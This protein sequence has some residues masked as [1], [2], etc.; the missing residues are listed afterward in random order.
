MSAPRKTIKGRDFIFGTLPASTALKVELAIAPVLAD[1]L[2]AFGAGSVEKL[3][4]EA[5]SLLTARAAGEVLK[6]LSAEDY[7]SPDGSPHMG[8]QTLMETVFAHVTI[9]VQ[10]KPRTVNLDQDFTGKAA[11]KYLVLV[12]ALKVNFADFF[13]AAPSSSSP[14]EAPQA[15]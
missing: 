15:A 13:P 10:P 5:G 8:L 1:A 2:A 11:D 3:S 4:E 7:T 12:E 14:A 6:R 9:V